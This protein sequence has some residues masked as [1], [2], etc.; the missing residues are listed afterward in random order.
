MSWSERK[1]HLTRVEC[2]PLVGP[3]CSEWLG[4]HGHAPNSPL[5]LTLKA[6]RARHIHKHRRPQG[7]AAGPSLLW[8]PAQTTARRHRTVTTARRHRT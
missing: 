3:V 4:P 1:A 7:H 8:R 6:T 5:R 2:P